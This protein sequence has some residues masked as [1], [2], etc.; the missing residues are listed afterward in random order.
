MSGESSS[1]DVV[2]PTLTPTGCG[3]RQELDVGAV[4]LAGALPHPRKWAEVS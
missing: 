3:R 1:G 2:G 4:G